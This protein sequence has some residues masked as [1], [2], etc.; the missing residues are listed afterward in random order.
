MKTF[1]I[2]TL[3][4]ISI[5][6][7]YSVT[8]IQ[9]D[10]EKIEQN[11]IKESKIKRIQKEKIAK[12]KDMDSKDSEI[13]KFTNN[14]NTYHS[15]DSKKDFIALT[16]LKYGHSVYDEAKTSIKSNSKTFDKITKALQDISGQKHIVLNTKISSLLKSKEATERFKKLLSNDFGLSDELIEKNLKQNYYVWDWVKSLSR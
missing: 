14:I 8:A 2:L 13:K 7:Y 12:E 10:K 9:E 3:L 4:I 5:I 11:K 16:D 6:I 15:V 1:A